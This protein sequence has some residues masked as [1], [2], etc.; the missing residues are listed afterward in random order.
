MNSSGIKIGGLLRAYSPKTEGIDVLLKG[1]ASA[2]QKLNNAGI[3]DVQIGVW[4][5]LDN[6]ASDCGRTYN[7]LCEMI[8]GLR[9]FSNT[10]AHETIDGDLFVSVLNDGIALQYARGLTHSLIL[11]WEAA[12]Y[13]DAILLKKMRAAVRS[14]ALAVGVA[15]P[16]IAEFVREGSIMNTLALWDIKALTEVGGFDPHDIKPRCADHYGESNAGVGEFIPLLKMRE[17]H[18]RP[19]LAVL[20]V[21]AQGKIEVQSERTELQRKKLESKQRRI[22]G[23]LAEIGKTAQDLRATIMPGYPN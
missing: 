5:N 7:A 22:N 13:V 12:S 18:K 9:I 3:H 20:E 1:L 23:M 19:V 15:L 6:P 8:N 4:A 10:R 14:G 16:E 11:S 2:I 17:Y 21:S